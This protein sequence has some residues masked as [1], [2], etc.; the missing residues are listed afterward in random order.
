MEAFQKVRSEFINADY[1]AWTAVGVKEL[2]LPD[3][4]IEIKATVVIKNQ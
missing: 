2:I 4:L 3:F 1:P